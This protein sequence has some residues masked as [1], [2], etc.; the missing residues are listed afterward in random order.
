M[1]VCGGCPIRGEV[2]V[3]EKKKRCRGTKIGGG[4]KLKYKKGKK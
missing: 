2:G 1:C 4:N 3:E